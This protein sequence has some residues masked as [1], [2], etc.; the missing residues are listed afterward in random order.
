MTEDY[1]RAYH[2]LGE[3]LLV[4]VEFTPSD[5]VISMLLGLMTSTVANI[6]DPEW[7]KIKR[8]AL[9]PCGK[10]GCDCHTNEKPKTVA[11]LD[12]TRTIILRNRAQSPAPCT[13][14]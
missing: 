13:D 8:D 3:G 4:L 5:A 9:L 10:P 7:E 6:P 14:G 11:L 12:S 2:A 1:I